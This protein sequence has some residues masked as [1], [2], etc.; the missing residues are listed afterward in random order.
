MANIQIGSLPTYTGDTTGVFLVM[1]DS[2]NTQT[3]KVEK[4]TLITGGGGGGGTHFGLTL[5]PNSTYNL[6]ITSPY[7]EDSFGCNADS[8]MAFP[9]SPCRDVSISGLTMDFYRPNGATNAR[10]KY[11][12]YDNDD[13]LLLPKNKLVESPELTPGFFS[14]VQY[15]TNFTFNAG[16]TYW[17]AIAF[18]YQM[19]GGDGEVSGRGVY[20]NGILTIGAPN[21]N[22]G[23]GVSY[24]T[25]I[26]K[27]DFS[28]IPSVW[29]PATGQYYCGTYLL[30]RGY[31]G[32]TSKGKL[33]EIRIKTV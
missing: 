23:Y 21:I 16:Q 1:N 15:N 28:S 25:A 19:T 11:L 33:P 27:S 12:I 29:V 13:S 18:N 7:I 10:L 3:F 17:I 24:K 22:D 2:G 20:A 9:F 31:Y 4:E 5:A 30:E 32:A 26:S 14:I 8:I 6:A